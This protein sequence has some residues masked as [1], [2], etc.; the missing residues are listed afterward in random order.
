MLQAPLILI[1]FALVIALG[2][3]F[4]WLYLRQTHLASL[5][6]PAGSGSWPPAAPLLFDNPRAWLAVRTTD[7]HSLVDAL[8]LRHI[9]PC[10]WA[11]APQRAE[12]GVFV[13]PP[14]EGWVLLFGAGLPE[15][16]DDVDEF[17]KFLT[18]L[19]RRCGLV[20]YF[21]TDAIFHHHA[22]VKANDGRIVRA[23]AWADEVLWNQGELTQAERDLRLYCLPYDWRP[24][25]VSPRARDQARHNCERIPMLASRWGIEPRAVD[26]QTTG[27][28]PGVL[29]KLPHHKLH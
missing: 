21:S 25:H 13:S 8:D 11:D 18:A 28:R 2:A 23:Y 10:A 17:F 9:S 3:L 24:D 4:W 19:S 12:E 14:I 27:L 29:G 5:L 16:S 22:W 6:K 1:P 20:T 7:V 15:P 26:A